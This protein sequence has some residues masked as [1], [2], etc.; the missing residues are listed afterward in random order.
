VK[1]LKKVLKNVKQHVVLF[2][3]P[4]YAAWKAA[5]DTEDASVLIVMQG[6]C[7]KVR[8]WHLLFQLRR[9]KIH[10][11]LQPEIILQNRSG[12]KSIEQKES[13]L[14]S[15][16]ALPYDYIALISTNVSLRPRALSIMLHAIKKHQQDVVFSDYFPLKKKGHIAL[17]PGFS[18]DFLRSTYYLGDV[19]LYRSTLFSKEQISDFQKQKL[20]ACDAALLALEKT[21]KIYH[22]PLPLYR[23]TTSAEHSDDL[24]RAVKAHLERSKISGEVFPG[25]SS[26]SCR[27]KYKICGDELVS[28]VIPN[29]NHLQDL[30]R[31]IDSIVKRTSYAH[32]EI[33][34]MENGSDDPALQK[35]Y[36]ELDNNEVAHVC[37]WEQPYNFAAICNAAS[38]IANGRYLL[39]LNNDTEV[40]T[41]EWLEEMVMYAQRK[42][43]GVVGVKLLY[44]S[45]EVQHGGVLIG[46]GG[47]AGHAYKGLP[48]T[49]TRNFSQLQLVHN[50][51]A[52]TGACMMIRKDL[53][54]EVG[55]MDV[56]LA[57]AYNDVDLCLRLFQMGYQ[58]V[59]TPYAV[60]Y[61]DE[62]KSRGL[63]TLAVN[64]ERF[65]G[66]SAYFM[67]KWKKT[68]EQGDPYFHPAYSRGSETFVLRG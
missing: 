7:G 43:V 4:F 55:G 37:R 21:K 6:K 19:V 3:L 28:I 49:D 12:K 41:P 67:R 54:E 30:K 63:D 36:E 42:D 20:N 52:V 57:V 1:S 29:K 16:G 34:V 10:F 5:K 44:P 15:K 58:H 17:L 62:S 66:E 26:G 65:I 61:H 25:Q 24:L 51:M 23:T 18:A 2:H 56:Q 33:I 39:F 38:R 46:V 47:I 48:A 53:Y 14:K 64:S 31:C 40:I 22:I 8:C 60:L 32:Y 45:G 59:F 27:I 11:H 68:L 9:Q 35:Y 50:C 13:L